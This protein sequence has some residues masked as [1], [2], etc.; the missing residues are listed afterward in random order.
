VNDKLLV[1]TDNKATLTETYE[2]LNIPLEKKVEE[3]L[4]VVEGSDLKE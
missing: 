2:K 3:E 1:I 4:T